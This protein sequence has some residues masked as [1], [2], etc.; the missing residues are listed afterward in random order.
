MTF[1]VHL[2]ALLASGAAALGALPNHKLADFPIGFSR[3]FATSGAD[4][5]NRHHVYLNSCDPAKSLCPA[6][7]AGR[8]AIA[9]E[10]ARE[11]HAPELAVRWLDAIGARI[12]ANPA[13]DGAFVMGTADG[14]AKLYIYEPLPDLPV[15]LGSSGKPQVRAILIRTV[16]LPSSQPALPTNEV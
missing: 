15:A 4:Q 13:W 12:K 11:L 16:R 10:W 14:A 5:P 8:L 3:K 1:V 2:V 6:D 9:R 7:P